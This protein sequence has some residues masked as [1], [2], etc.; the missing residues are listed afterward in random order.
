MS[1]S[2]CYNGCAEITSDKCVRYTGIDIPVLGITT[3]DSLAYVEQ[4]IANF[5]IITLDGSGIKPNI[6]NAIVCQAIKDKLPPACDGASVVDYL[7]ALIKVVC[8]INVSGNTNSS[9]IQQIQNFIDDLES[10]YTIGCLSGVAPNAGTHD[11]V[12]AIIDRLCLFISDVTNNYVTIASLDARIAAYLASIVPATPAVSAKMIP[13][14]AYEYYGPASNFAS[15]GKGIASLGYDKVYICNGNYSTPDKRGVVTAGAIVGF[16]SSTALPASINPS[17][18]ANPNYAVTGVTSAIYGSNTNAL[19]VNQMPQHNH[20]ATAFVN[21]SPHT[22]TFTGN[23]NISFGSGTAPSQA[24]SSTPGPGTVIGGTNSA[25]KTNLTVDV[26]V[27][28]R[29]NG[30]PFAIIQPTKAAHYIMYIP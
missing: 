26:T 10:N 5:L 15:D 18:P 14:V 1:C 16:T 8:Q 17:N 22:H 20:T 13:Y 30:D 28:N 7:I 27:Q 9:Q 11:I 6:D 4:Q 23:T 2:N 25:E 21:E 29:G 3:G 19:L 24:Q 12:Q